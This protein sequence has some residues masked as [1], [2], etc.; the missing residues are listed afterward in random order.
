VLGGLTAAAALAALGG[1][2]PASATGLESFELPPLEMPQLVADIK[3]RNQKVL[4]EAEESFQSSGG[5]GEPGEGCSQLGLTP[6]AVVAAL[7][8]LEWRYAACLRCSISHTVTH[9]RLLADLLKTLK[10]RSDANRAGRKKDL[11]DRYCRRQ[12]EIGAGD[13]A[14]LRW[15]GGRVKRGWGRIKVTGLHACC[16]SRRGGSL[17][18]HPN[19]Q[20][21]RAA[22]PSPSN[23]CRP[24]LRLPAVPPPLPCPAG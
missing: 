16:P 9:G 4:D 1:S 17:T 22:T 24:P 5:N 20:F 3:K 23:S 21:P 8:A 13:C 7:A 14:G 11:E 2:R 19:R 15:V 12:A 10:E 6:A 18:M